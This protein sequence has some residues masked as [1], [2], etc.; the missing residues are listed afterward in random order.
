[1]FFNKEPVL[2]DLN[3]NQKQDFHPKLKSKIDNRGNISTPELHDMWPFLS[4]K[5]VA[6]NLIDSKDV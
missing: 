4:G 6:D 1:M 3:I 2:I 5:E